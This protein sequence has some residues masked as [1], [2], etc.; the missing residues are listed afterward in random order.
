VYLPQVQGLRPLASADVTGAAA[1]LRR[2]SCHESGCCG[3]GVSLDEPP[4]P[5]QNPTA[6][7]MTPAGSGNFERRQSGNMSTRFTPE[8]AARAARRH[9]GSREGRRK[10]LLRSAPTEPEPD[11]AVRR[12]VDT[13]RPLPC[14]TLCRAARADGNLI[15]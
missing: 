1:G 2:S 12:R 10:I 4:Q 11:M 7:S 8:T 6:A 5:K 14:R 9:S 15:S 13:I 3:G